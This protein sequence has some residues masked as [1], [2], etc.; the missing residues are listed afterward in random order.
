MSCQA[1]LSLSLSQCH[2]DTLSLLRRYTRLETSHRNSIPMHSGAGE[3]R[4]RVWRWDGVVRRLSTH[5]CTPARK[6]VHLTQNQDR[7]Q[8]VQS[9]FPPCLV[10][11]VAWS[12]NEEIVDGKK[13]ES[14]LLAVNAYNSKN[15]LHY[16]LAIVICGLLPGA[17]RAPFD[18]IGD[19][20]WRLVWVTTRELDG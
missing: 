1:F 4:T 6:R 16:C 10:S 7:V 2:G 20:C 12:K 5:R 17:H 19:R 8:P 14:T 15:V 11:Q 9:P 3:R 13:R 18:P